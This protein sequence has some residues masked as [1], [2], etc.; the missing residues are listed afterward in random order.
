M[1][2]LGWRR[3]GCKIGRRGKEVGSREIP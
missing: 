1:G 2:D 3:G